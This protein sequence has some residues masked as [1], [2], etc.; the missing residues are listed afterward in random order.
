MKKAIAK[1]L[2]ETPGQRRVPATSRRAQPDGPNWLRAH[3]R[4]RAQPNTRLGA[5]VASCTNQ[6]RGNDGLPARQTIQLP[7]RAT[8]TATNTRA[9]ARVATDHTLATWPLPT[10]M[11]MVVKTM[12]AVALSM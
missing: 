4:P 3:E 6:R 9:E 8:C 10:G 12:T 11:A 7:T 2:R 5:Y 1:R